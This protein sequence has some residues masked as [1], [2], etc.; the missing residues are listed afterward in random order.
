M[1]RR[2]PVDP[3][4]LRRSRA[5]RG[6]LVATVGVG[7]VQVVALVAQAWLLARLI[8]A[9]FHR[10]PVTGRAVTELIMLAAVV[11]VRAGLAWAQPWLG[12]RAAARVK[13]ELRR[14]V[15]AARLARPYDPA[16]SQ[17][18][19]ATVVGAGLDALDGWY[20]RYLPQL[21]LGVLAP[22]VI[23][24][25]VALTDP[26]SALVLVVTLPLVPVFMVLVGLATRHQ[27]DRRWRARAVLG[28]HFADL[29]TGLTTLQAFGRAR[30]QV[31][32]LVHSETRHRTETM[33]TLRVAFL[34]ALVLELLASLSVAVVA[35]SVGLRV[36]DAELA[37]FP[38]MFVLVLAP[39]AFLPLRQVGVHYHDAADGV[40]AADEALTIIES[41]DADTAAVRDTGDAVGIGAVDLVRLAGV[42]TD[43]TG[44]VT[45]EARVGEL[46]VV[47]GPSGAGKTTALQVVMGWLR[48]TAGTVELVSGDE[49]RPLD[50][51]RVAAWHRQVAW[52]PQLPGLLPGTVADNITFGGPV[53]DRDRL[54]RV[55]DRCG[56]SDIALDQPVGDDG[57]GLSVGQRRRVAIAR[58]VLR[59]VDGGARWLLLDEPTAGLD[60]D[61]E[62][63][64]LA[65]LPAGVGVIMVSHRP[66]VVARADRVI[67]VAPLPPGPSDGG[68]NPAAAAA[69]P[70]RP[71]TRSGSRSGRRS[72][73]GP[74]DTSGPGS[75]RGG[76]TVSVLLGVL[77]AGSGV[78]LIGTAGWLLSRAAEHPPVLHLM[79]AVVAVRF[80]GIGK[81]VFRYAERLVSHRVA[82]A[83]ES[84]LRVDTYRRLA[85]RLVPAR[86]RDD[87][88]SRLTRDVGAAVDLT[89][90][91]VLP[92]LVAGVVGIATVAFVATVSPPS[93]VALAVGLLVSGV[94]GPRLGA[95]LARRSQHRLAD[96]RGALA[97]EVGSV[98]RLAAE[99]TAHGL[100]RQRLDR[101]SARDA[102]LCAV[103]QRAATA[104]GV[105]SA[106]QV[107]GLGAVTVTALLVAAP[108]VRAGTLAPT[109]VAVLALLPLALADVVAPL[110]A[111]ALTRTASRAAL[112]RVARIGHGPRVAERTHL[113]EHSDD[114]DASTDA[115]P[116]PGGVA[117]ADASVGWSAD[118]PV[119]AGVSLT[120]TAGERVALVGPSGLGKTTLG[121]TVAG[122]LPPLTGQVDVTGRVGLLSQDAHL[123]D[124]TVRENLRLARPDA[125]DAELATVLQRVGLRF[126]LDRR[127]G[128]H[129]STV[130]GGEARR[131]A[132]ARLLL[133]RVDVLVLD[134]P[135]E[136][137]DHDTAERLLHDIDQ[138]WPTAALVVITHDPALVA[139]V[140]GARVVDLTPTDVPGSGDAAGASPDAPAELVSA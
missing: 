138:L 107:A 56:G 67:E 62:A 124:T 130:S 41:A 29:V 1:S 64:V 91:V 55:L 44:P 18:R 12:H 73:D 137:L 23:V 118:S 83:R 76:L 21:V 77:A 133:R 87:L 19:L 6:H 4:L 10:T 42:A 9:L 110:P 24:V 59:V 93:A 61:S 15:M 32:G 106:V 111:A 16:V 11:A 63:A 25:T 30:R 132:L 43:R 17:G 116:G 136:H 65:G 140:L 49:S 89:V 94:V 74:V 3:R 88:V 82:L 33:R 117:V 134:E 66:A 34:S 79:V 96:R 112:A 78:G 90:R 95:A 103:E 13:S 105:A 99:L 38:A 113:A 71:G 129:G 100:G 125:S 57:T 123:F 126:A 68:A 80:F 119:L 51:E 5:T 27:L 48:P 92:V 81:G 122:L 60:A 8:T 22:A 108:A 98:H 58:A 72:G 128:E 135:T 53:T 40:A 127:V 70:H 47:T 50:P 84:R 14:D 139:P 104:T 31:R 115:V 39:E 121:L 86:G 46:T 102:A 109:M 45:A 2:G 20:A 28:H 52:V 101:V 7:L 131:L 26:L 54:R 37:L 114:R 120:V 69:G 36:V 35:V 97:D 75:D 85:D